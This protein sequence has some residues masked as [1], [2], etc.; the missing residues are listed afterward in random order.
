MYKRFAAAVNVPVLANITEFGQT[1]LFTVAELRA[2]MST[3]ALYPLLG[4]PRDEQGGARRLSGVAARRHAEERSSDSMQTRAEL[5]DYLG[6]HAYE[7]K[8]D[9]LYAAS[10]RTRRLE[11]EDADDRQRPPR[12]SRRN[13]SRCPASSAGNTA[14]CTVGRTGND[15]HYRGLRHPRHRRC[16]RIRGDR[17]P[18][19]ST[20]SCRPSA[21]LAAYKRE[22][23]DRCAAFPRR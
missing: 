19:R 9:A 17:V 11:N 4:V 23:Q 15:L 16:L 3:I 1:P 6:Y 8:L 21:E 20:A 12:R 13:R 10:C 22:A 5:Y 14:L 2:P 18:A 7:Q